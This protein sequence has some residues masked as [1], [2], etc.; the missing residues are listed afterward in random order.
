MPAQFGSDVVVDMMQRFGIPYASLN[1]GSSFRGL[2]D[3]IVNYGKNNPQIITCGHEE[4][5]IQIAHGY[6]RATGKPMVAI[7]HDVVGLLHGCMAIYYAHLDR[8]PVIVMGGTGPMDTTRRRPHIDWTHTALVQGNAVRDYVRW[9]DQ[10]YTVEG[11]PESFARGHRIAMTHPQGPVY[12]CYDAAL[13]EDPIVG[14]IPEIDPARSQPPSPIMGDP[15]ALGKAADL[16]VNAEMPVIITEYTG[17]SETGYKA[18]I[19]LAEALGAGVVDWHG[20]QNFPNAHPLNLWGTDILRR[21]DVVLSLDLSDIYGPITELDRVTRRTVPIV[22]SG[23][24]IIDI[25]HRDMRANGWSQEFQKFTEVDLF[26]HGD[27]STTLPALTKLVQER[28]SSDKARGNQISKRADDLRRLHD[29]QREKWNTEAK[30]DWDAT[31]VSLPRLSMEM[32][33]ALQSEDW[34]VCMNPLRDTLHMYWDLDRWGRHTGD[35]LGTATQIGMNLGI[36]LAHKGSGKLVAAIQTDGD[37]MFDTGALWIA[38]HDQIPILLVMFNNRAYYN[39]WE[40]QIRM[41]EVRERDVRMA[42]LGQEI[43]NPA[44]DFAAI[45]KGFGWY[46]EGPIDQPK[47]V[48]AAIRR[49]VER[50]KAGQP[51]LIDVVTQYR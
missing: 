22:P 28:V 50:V 1:P 21:A 37:L 17:R 14:P 30:K 32:R 16:L 19:Q 41:A 8:A 45:A 13:Q 2:H 51:A 47:D 20:R 24:K 27:T 11:V 12:L 10:P 36:A 4:L 6:A 5:A 38:M 31:P 7:V 40:H 25:G 35:D 9:D 15:T 29:Q 44:P 39:D 18:L 48:G 34:V 49:G 3:S 42:Y 33:D 46:A 26:I 43:A 23:C